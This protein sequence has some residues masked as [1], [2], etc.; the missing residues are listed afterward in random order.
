MPSSVADL[1]SLLGTALR[2][3]RSR[4]LLTVG[5]VL[6]AAIGVAAAVVGPV[7]QSASTASYLISKLRSEP[8][9]VT[10]VTLDFTPTQ[11]TDRGTAIAHAKAMVDPSAVSQFERPDL[12]LWTKRLPVGDYYALLDTQAVLAAPP[13]CRGLVVSGRCPSR[14][15]ETLLLKFD[16][17]HTKTSIGDA[18]PVTGVHRPLIVVGTYRLSNRDTG[19][20]N[21]LSRFASVLPQATG[22]TGVSPYY[23]APWIVTADTITR[24][25][26][27]TWYLRMDYRVRTDV[28]TTLGDLQQA[29]HQVARLH[30]VERAPSVGG[31]LRVELGG[32]GLRSVVH[33]AAQR[34]DT[35]QQ[36]VTP[37]VLSLILVALVLLVRLLAAAMDLRRAELALASLRGIG[38]RQLWVLGLLEPLLV[39]AAS[40]PVGLIAGYLGAKALVSAWLVPGLPLQFGLSSLVLAA[41]VLA[42]TLATAILTV[43]SA[44]AEPLSVQIAG[45]RRPARSSRWG[46]VLQLAVIAAAVVVLSAALGAQGR[47]RP[48]ASNLLLPI[49][50]AVAT[51]LLTTLAAA[52][53]ARWQANRS[54]RRRGLA[55]YVAARTIAR[56]REGTWAI[57]PLTA[58]LAIAVFAA[59]VYATAA[60]WRASDAA[61]QVGAEAS[62]EVHLPLAQAVAVTHQ[63]D[64][65]GK[66]LMAMAAVGDAR[67]VKV[68]VDAPRFA[69]VAEWPNSWTPGMSAA[70]VGRAISPGTP[71]TFTGRRLRLTVDNAADRHSGEILLTVKVVTSNGESRSVPIGPFPS[72]TATRSQPV[73]CS[74]GCD[75]TGLSIGGPGPFAQ[76]MHGTVT[77]RNVRADGRSLPYFSQVGWRGDNLN[78]GML[79][80]AS[81][82][83]V[84]TSGQ[85]IRAEL[86]SH[87]ELTVARLLP[88]DVP[89][90]VPMI[91]GRTAAP[92][93]VARHGAAL[94]LATSSNL[95][96][97][98]QRVATTE[99]TPVFGPA[100]LLMDATSYTRTAAVSEVETQVYILA[101]GDTPQNVVSGLGEHGIASP[102]RLKQVH[103]ALDHDAYALALNL[104]LVVTV[105]VIL[106]AVA[107]LAVNMAVQIPARRRDAAS[108]RVVGLS[109]RSIVTAVAAELTT[110]LGAAA[111]AGI[112]AGA[113]AQYVVVR[114]L[115][116]GYS[117]DFST[118]RVLPS[119]DLPTVTAILAAAFV[120]L[121]A[122]AVVLGNLT[123]RGARTATLRETA[124]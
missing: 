78:T 39:L 74:S 120:V 12:S 44:L 10:G 66:W 88:L 68:L 36:T 2:G 17:V 5:S 91:S 49:L 115:T 55:R 102:V 19:R 116:L 95:R 53:A 38:R 62:Y 35:A 96:V 14:P 41:G 71:L 124:A 57:L 4:Q 114:T 83:R 47:S 108:L 112:L 73:P 15:G 92:R 76:V 85:T 111:I 82:T 27:R 58:A 100:G 69:R 103:Q 43:R 45:V 25:Q 37:A 52:L 8:D 79:G 63:V 31:F 64:P 23:P 123:I 107:G 11:P 72:G 48:T 87:G 40:I 80:P 65:Q 3:L 94:T 86:D 29:T 7:Y 105:L 26:P 54:V 109:R 18:I 42:A 6:L 121:L 122:V 22:G 59:G 104:Y 21:D 9:F 60:D 99:S 70:D 56:R 51:G 93:V 101:R 61:T 84:E 110:V 1:R 117:D 46:L 89:A 119:L 33:E 24:M 77:I 75:V 67:G 16:A 81:V 106:L 98:V 90:A 113:L 50:L 30:A 28:E 32:N 34:K 13:D 118:P 97:Q 20:F